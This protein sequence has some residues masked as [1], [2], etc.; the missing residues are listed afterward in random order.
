MGMIESGMAGHKSKASEPFHTE[1]LEHVAELQRTDPNVRSALAEVGG[2]EE[3]LG[4]IEA[5]S[6]IK[7]SGKDKQLVLAEVDLLYLIAVSGAV[8]LCCI[9]ALTNFIT[10]RLPC[11]KR[12][13]EFHFH[14]LQVLSTR[15]L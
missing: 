12:S 10:G 15:F 3:L 11:S 4:L 13:L 8:L 7:P 2:L 14:S 9:H 6:E 1:V 5:G